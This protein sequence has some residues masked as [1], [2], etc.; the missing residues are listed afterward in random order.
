MFC[1]LRLGSSGAKGVGRFRALGLTAL[2]L[3]LGFRVQG[4]FL[5]FGVGGFLSCLA[6]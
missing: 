2:D 5:G 6:G 3:G 1:D 4:F